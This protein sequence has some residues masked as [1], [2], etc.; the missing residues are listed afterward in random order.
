MLNRHRNWSF[1]EAQLQQHKQVGIQLQKENATAACALLTLRR[2]RPGQKRYEQVRHDLPNVVCRM[3]FLT[4]CCE[5]ISASGFRHFSVIALILFTTCAFCEEMGT[6]ANRSRGGQGEIETLDAD[7]AWGVMVQN[8]L[9]LATSIIRTTIGEFTSRGDFEFLRC[10]QNLIKA[11][12]RQHRHLER[13]GGVR[14]PKRTVTVD[15]S[16]VCATCGTP[17]DGG[18]LADVGVASSPGIN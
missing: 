13:I 8:L 14:C 3:N 7:A 16:T 11:L 15:T 9:L 12:L 17:Y 10:L 6:T 4:A 18:P 1:T 5:Q 2:F